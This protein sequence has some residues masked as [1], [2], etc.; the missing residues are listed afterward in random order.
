MIDFIGDY[1]A[2]QQ[3]RFLVQSSLTSCKIA[4]T[5]LHRKG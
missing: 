3:L 4:D 1:G 5:I 2:V